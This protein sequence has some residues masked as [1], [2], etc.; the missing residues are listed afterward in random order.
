MIAAPI[1]CMNRHP[2]GRRRHGSHIRR[3][4]VNT[5]ESNVRESSDVESLANERR[6]GRQARVAWLCVASLAVL[7]VGTA[8]HRDEAAGASGSGTAP[9]AASS[10]IGSAK[11]PAVAAAPS[12]PSTTST[13]DPKAQ[14]HEL[15]E[16]LKPLKK[17]V[18]SDITDKQ[19]IHGQALLT[20]MRN[21]GTA[22]GVEALSTLRS[23]QAGEEPWPIEVERGLLDVAAHAAPNESRPLLNALVTQYGPTLE[24]RTHALV[25]LSE[26][27]PDDT[28]KILEPLVT[29]SRPN[30]TLPPAEFMVSS[31]VT[32]CEKTGR[33]PVKEL[34][35]V[36][37]NLF[38]DETAR[39]RAVKELGRHK[40][41]LATQALS[42][43]LVES[44]GD[45]YLRRMAAQGLRDTLDKESAC[46]IFEIV[47]QR[48]AD[49]G[50]LDFMR[51]M[52]DKN[53]SDAADKTANA[54]KATPEPIKKNK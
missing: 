23:K 12:A 41:P 4:V 17:T 8:C 1:A 11:S 40:D 20:R 49:Q 19:F 50:M 14:V 16:T 45:A 54:K 34:A 26:T 52:L 43:I 15:V 2:F 10:A 6:G 53:C 44:T 51:D 33:S 37:T 29:K 9:S 27:W 28:I 18:T 35:D 42:A 36:A 25:L 48:E 46:K 13:S 22:V 5:R 21:G 47:A 38:Q 32:A 39:I 24:L 3:A 7:V 30:Q 31:W